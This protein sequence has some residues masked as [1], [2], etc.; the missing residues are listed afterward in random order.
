MQDKKH[1]QEQSMWGTTLEQGRMTPREGG[2]E[3][4]GADNQNEAYDT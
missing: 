1:L 4:V 3:N 2:R